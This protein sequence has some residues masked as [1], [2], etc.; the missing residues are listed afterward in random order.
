MAVNSGNTPELFVKSTMNIGEGEGC[1]ENNF[2]I[3]I[4]EPHK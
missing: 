4:N 1:Y 3:D 2:T